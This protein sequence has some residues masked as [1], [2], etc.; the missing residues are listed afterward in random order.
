MGRLIRQLKNDKDAGEEARLH[1]Y[2]SIN[3]FVRKAP[4]PC[5]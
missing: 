2:K 5:S 3:G 1:P 4:D